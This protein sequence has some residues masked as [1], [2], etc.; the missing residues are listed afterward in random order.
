[1]KDEGL[2]IR[3]YH[4]IQTTSSHVHLIATVLTRIAAGRSWPL[5]S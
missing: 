4:T 3:R 5:Y 2:M 1:M